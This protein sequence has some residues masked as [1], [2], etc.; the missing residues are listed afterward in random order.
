M[1][2]KESNKTKCK[3]HQVERTPL[4]YSQIQSDLNWLAN[5]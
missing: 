2:S 4:N 3:Y 1:C 5:Q